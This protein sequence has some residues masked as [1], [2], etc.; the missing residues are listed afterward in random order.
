LVL[1]EVT[2]RRGY[3]IVAK[4]VTALGFAILYLA[5]FTAQQLYG[6]IG[7]RAAFALAALIT[8]GAMVYAVVLDE[9]LIALLSLLGGFL[10]PVIVSTGENLPVPLFVYVSILSV[11]AMTC[12]YY[13]RWRAVDVLA[14]IGTFLLYT[15]WFEKFYRPAMRMA[16]G[17]PEQMA[18]ALGWLG[19]FFGIY[20]VLPILYE[21]AKKIKA[22]KEDVLLVLVNAAVVFYYLWT[23]LFDRYRTPLAFCALGLCMVHLV[24]MAIVFKRCKDDLNL[25]QVLLAIGLFF[26]TIAVPI[27]FKM[28]AIA[29]AWAA[30]GVILA[31]IGLRYRSVL[32]QVAGA[33]S[34]FLSC[35]NLLLHLP[36]HT[37]TFSLVL[38]PTFGTWCFVAGVMFICHIIYRRTCESP[39]CPYGL[40]AQILYGLAATL[41]FAA[42]T[43]E[44]YYHCHYN[45]LDGTNYGWRGQMVIF[46]ATVV[47]FVIRPVRPAGK[48]C[49]ALAAISVMAGSVFSGIFLFTSLHKAGFT[50]FVNPDFA[51]VLVFI[52]ALTLYHIICRRISETP[53]DQNGRT[54]QV[55]FGLIGLLLFAAATMEW[56]CHC[57]YNLKTGGELHYISRGQ[58]IIFAAIT[59]LF[60]IR[61]VCPRGKLADVLSMIL[62][63]AGSVYTVFALTRLHTKSFVIFANLDFAV[64]LIFIT[65]MLVCHIKY[66]LISGAGKDG[67]GPASQIIYGVLGL[68]LLFATAA[69]WYWHCVYNLGAE[70]LSDVLV[71]GQVIIF[72]IIML[73]FVVRPVCPRGVV[74]K[75]LATILAGVGAM[76]IT[77]TFPQIHNDSY[78]IFANVNFGTALLF[79]TAL[80]ASAWLLNWTSKQE[81]YNRK[82]AF[83]FALWAI[84]VLWVLLNE[85]IYL[86]WYCRNR[87]LRPLDN[88]EF[89]A[90]MCISV[91]WA[92]YGAVL[93]IIGFW[94][95]IGVL[96]YIAIALF[97]LLLVKIFIWDTR[98]IENVYRIAA[99]LATGVVLVGTSYLYQFLKKKGFFE[100]MPAKKNAD[101]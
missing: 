97:T 52:A 60:A 8:A 29:I 89:L 76:F 35:G 94:Q 24:M 101:K 42:V 80:F 30:E 43:M 98:R 5:V 39:E 48:I 74:S 59:L 22:E 11:G 26:L 21:L 9:I 3:G 72:S 79:V 83:A 13:R 18:I 28:N 36:M 45:V 84:F 99:F 16:E 31:I 65:A 85:E 41:L 62:L 69:E 23:I 56:Y 1:G 7:P 37:E 90:H 49:D 100:A 32:T 57:M 47:L 46:A 14:F 2:R 54:A 20:L 71:K 12:A 78:V 38:N 50:I 82:F 51:V 96:R 88:W 10:T 77:I 15:G 27:Y 68:L 55:L 87:F 91:M 53:D 17:T 92:V 70:G 4:G 34:L 25:R 64:I 66:R 58:M 95:K 40:A 19:V 63:A 44:W 6:L 33:V 75:V 93:M 81:Q 73:L 86:Y 67:R 61:P